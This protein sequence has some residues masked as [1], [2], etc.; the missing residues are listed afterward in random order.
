MHNREAISHGHFGIRY[1][2]LR[3]LINK[4]CDHVVNISED[5]LR[6]LNLPDK[7]SVIYNFIPIPEVYRIPF[8]N[9]E[10]KK[11]LF[12]GGSADIKGFDTLVRA[13]PYIDNDIELHIGGLINEASIPAVLKQI[14][15]EKAS[16]VRMLG[17]LENP[18]PVIDSCDVLITPFKYPHFSR[19]AIEAFAFGKPVIGSNVVGMSEI[20]DHRQNG[21]LFCVNDERDLAEK[22][23]YMFSVPE[24]ARAMGKLGREK[25]IKQFSP[26]SSMRKIVELYLTI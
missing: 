17:V 8:Q 1:S 26:D 20:I 9:N 7:S 21:L 4:N 24:A 15:D 23:N 11:V 12:L 5:N 2:I 22:I 16:V 3:A 14:L 18:Y 25:A 19:P 10:S 6:R 13:L